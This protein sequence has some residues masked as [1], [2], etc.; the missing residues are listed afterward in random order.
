MNGEIKMTE[1]N[2]KNVFLD[3]NE[4]TQTN[5]NEK[6]KNLKNSER[7]VETSKDNFSTITRMNG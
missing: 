1:N 3:G 5:L 4:I 2:E 6:L 7:I